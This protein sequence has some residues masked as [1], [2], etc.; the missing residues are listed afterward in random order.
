MGVYFG[1]PAYGN[2]HSVTHCGGSSCRYRTDPEL[3]RLKVQL[4]LPTKFQPPPL[5]IITKG[6]FLGLSPHGVSRHSYDV[7]GQILSHAW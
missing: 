3:P 2:L 5:L 7:S 6:V 4:F 1:G